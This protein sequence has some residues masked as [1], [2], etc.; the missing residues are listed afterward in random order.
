MITLEQIIMDIGGD[1][2]LTKIVIES[3][4]DGNASRTLL[5]KTK[6]WLLGHEYL[7]LHNDSESCGCGVDDLA[8]CG[9]PSLECVAAWCLLCSCGKRHFIPS[10]NTIKE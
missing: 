4:R 6:E 8:P 7:G 2:P 5:D 3:V 1:H 10:E 9:C